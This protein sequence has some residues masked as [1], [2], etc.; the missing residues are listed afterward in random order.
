[1]IKDFVPAKTSVSTGVVVKQHILERNRQRPAA[2]ILTHEEYTG[3]ITKHIDEAYI[4]S[5][6]NIANRTISSSKLVHIEGGQGGLFDSINVPEFYSASFSAS[7]PINQISPQ[8]T[9]SWSYTTSGVSGSVVVTQSSQE[10]FYT[11]EL[12]GTE[13]IASDGE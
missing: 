11:G 3:S 10:E 6:D 2:V 7:L 12:S 9:Q 1:M 8:I 4:S 13:V 5:S